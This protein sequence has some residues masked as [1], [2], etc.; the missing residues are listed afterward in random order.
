MPKKSFSL[1]SNSCL[2]LTLLPIQKVYSQ[3]PYMNTK[4]DCS[5]TYKQQPKNVQSGQQYHK[6]IKP[7]W[8]TSLNYPRYIHICVSLFTIKKI[9]TLKNVNVH[10]QW[11][12]LVNDGTHTMKSYNQQERKTNIPRQGK[13][14]AILR[15]QSNCIR[16]FASLPPAL[17]SDI[18]SRIPRYC[19]A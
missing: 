7:L 19:A 5:Q 14:T 4:D 1:V 18:E 10:L 6:L 3:L 17:D 16:L 9:Q 2:P 8:T 12:S 11:E 13:I 15:M